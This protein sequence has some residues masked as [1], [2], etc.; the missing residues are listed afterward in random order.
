MQIEEYRICINDDT[1]VNQ[2]WEERKNPSLQI[3]VSKVI[4][5]IMKR[6]LNRFYNSCKLKEKKWHPHNRNALC[7]SFYYVNDNL[8]VNLDVPQMMCCLLWIQ[9]KN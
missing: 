9:E 7:W 1:E 2:V 8:K 5:E 4:G 6:K 3:E